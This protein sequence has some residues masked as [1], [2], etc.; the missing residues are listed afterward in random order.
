M[1]RK[2]ASIQKIVEVKNIEGA[3]LIQAY[4]VLGWWVVGKKDE[5]KVGDQV[6]YFE[7]DSFI[8]HKIAP[9][10]TKPNKEP[11]EYN[12]VKG[13]VLKTA[14]LRGKISQGLIVPLSI[15][16]DMVE[17]YGDGGYVKIGNKSIRLF[18]NGTDVTEILGIQKWEPP[19]PATLSGLVRGNF[20]TQLVQKTDQERI[21]NLYDEIDLD[22]EWEVTMKLDG[23]SFTLIKYEG[24][25]RACS[26]NLELKMVPENNKNSF[27]KM[28]NEIA[29]LIEDVDNIAIQMELMGEGVQGNKEKLKGHHAFVFDIFDIENQQYYTSKKRL[30][31]SESRGLKHTPVISESMKLTGMTID[32]ILEMADGP[33]INAK[34]R[35][36]LV[37][38]SLTNP[39][40]SFKAISNRWLLKNGE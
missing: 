18:E 20:P 9:F 22:D 17:E 12:G 3:D 37:F 25:I 10:L 15:L 29:P 1:E 33:S 19:I 30:A 16:S 13:E 2:L 4:R 38:K 6:V 11:R 23:S 40:T 32:N 8:P 5:F 21:Q 7:I 35:E 28:A 31:F 26:R 36:G 39:S 24:E 34:N 14:K 27:V